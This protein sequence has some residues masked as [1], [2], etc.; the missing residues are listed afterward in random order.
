[1]GGLD[2]SNETWY[3]HI[4]SVKPGSLVIINKN[5][6]VLEK[7]YYSFSNE[8]ENKKIYKKNI[9]YNLKFTRSQ[10]KTVKNYRSI[11]QLSGRVDSS[12]VTLLKNNNKEI[13]TYTFGYKEKEYDERKIRKK[14]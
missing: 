10:L 12:I 11:K 6:I 4:K 7:K 2:H 13:N 3:K 14:V 5:F 1:M 8:V 9:P